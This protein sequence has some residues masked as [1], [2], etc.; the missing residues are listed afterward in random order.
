[1]CYSAEVRADYAAFQR[2]FPG[3]RVSIKDFFAAY[4]RRK[5]QPMLRFPRAMD[6]L[7]AN[8]ASEEERAV[9]ALIDE[10]NVTQAMVHEQTLFAQRV[11]LVD[12]D[13][14]LL[15]KETKKA[16]TDKRV[17]TDKI[18][19]A[20][21]KIDDLKRVELKPR[22]S[23]IFP[24]WYAPV[25][26]MDEGELVLKPMRYLCRPAGKPAFYDTK[27]PGI[28]NARRDNLR[29]FWKGQFGRTHGLMIVNGFYENVK[30]HDR[31]HRALRPGE[32]PENVVLEFR[33]RPTQDMLIACVYSHWTPPEGS[34]EEALWSFAAVTDE[35]PPE[36]ADAGH[37]R[38]I[39]QLRPENVEAWL[40]P[41]ARS[42]DQLDEILEDKERPY[43]E[44][45]LAA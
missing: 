26:V 44:H 9:K 4:W 40:T 25:L 15:V 23:R 45:R 38:C 35:P 18:A 13:R 30:V 6:A 33:P 29:N 12:A 20:L 3:T 1:M 14:K 43:Y 41:Q 17:A 10:F 8:P 36:V 5:Q 28:Y 42:L 22:D 11:R 32:E 24:G 37:D 21:A 34:D 7:F 39:I 2:L 27:Y 31:E 19:N 16:L